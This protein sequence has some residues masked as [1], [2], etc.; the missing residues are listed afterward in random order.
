MKV[1]QLEKKET[2]YFS[3]GQCENKKNKK[4]LYITFKPIN[5]LQR[6]IMGKNIIF[7]VKNDKIM[8]IRYSRFNSN[9]TPQKK[10]RFERGGPFP[11]PPAP[12][13]V[14]RHQFFHDGRHPQDFFLVKLIFF[15]ILFFKKFMGENVQ[16]TF[17]NRDLICFVFSFL[18]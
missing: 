10:I 3:F 5:Q 13:P 9:N 8:S 14:P 2:S 12:L 4:I 1:Q 17:F 6:E 16:D 15:P 7:D 11:C 18:Y